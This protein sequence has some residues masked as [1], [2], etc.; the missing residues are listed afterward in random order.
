MPELGLQNLQDLLGA[1]GINWLLLGA[2]VAALFLSLYV[3]SD[4]SPAVRRVAWTI[5][6]AIVLMTVIGQ[7]L[8]S[9]SPRLHLGL[10]GPQLSYLEA[11][12]DAL[13]VAPDRDKLQLL[14][15]MGSYYTCV[16]KPNSIFHQYF[17][18]V[19]VFRKEGSRDLVEYRVVDGRVPALPVSEVS[20]STPEGGF[21]TFVVY[22][23][24][25]R[26]LGMSYGDESTNSEIR[27]HDVHGRV[28]MIASG[29]APQGS[30]AE[31]I[32]GPNEIVISRSRTIGRPT[33]HLRDSEVLDRWNR[34]GNVM[35]FRADRARDAFYDG[36]RPIKPTV[37][38]EE[39]TALALAAGAEFE[40][41][42][43]QMLP[44][45]AVYLRD[46]RERGV[47]GPYWQLPLRMAL[48]PIVVGAKS[49]RVHF[50][51]DDGQYVAYWSTRQYLP[52]AVV[53]ALFLI[54]FSIGVHA[55][56][57]SRRK[58]SVRR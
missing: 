30:F 12:D 43:K 50:V 11:Y 46:L 16:R 24:S 31:I 7:W 19:F 14:E 49:R 44:V 20:E 34:F 36:L 37:G 27:V 25:P 42:G 57:Q 17:E 41:P 21:A 9:R 45:G 55:F 28:T 56:M 22:N 26:A 47:A 1:N 5:F 58:R 54:L 51:A 40:V 18:W 53:G 52:E 39:A 35:V 2:S 38:A 33:D 32:E 6:A 10:V 29:E 13:L 8:D 23:V 15:A 4:A 3:R 48:R